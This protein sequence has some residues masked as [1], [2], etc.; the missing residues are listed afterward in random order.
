MTIHIEVAYATPER[1]WL[2]PLELSADA[3]I[4]QAIRASGVLSCFSEIDL[5]INSV[6][7]HGALKALD[8]RLRDKDRV[9]IYRP[10]TITPIEARRLRA[11]KP[12]KS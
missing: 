3:T 6:G 10:L 12:Q 2:R 1:Q 5:N 4:E 9:E 11:A 8:S 7:V